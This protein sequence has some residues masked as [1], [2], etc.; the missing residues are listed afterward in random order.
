ME[1]SPRL[2]FKFLQP[3]RSHSWHNDRL[4]MQR[5]HVIQCLSIHTSRFESYI[6]E[7]HGTFQPTISN[8]LIAIMCLCPDEQIR[9]N[10][11]FLPSTLCDAMQIREPDSLLHRSCDQLRER[12]VIRVIAT[13][14]QQIIVIEYPKN[15]CPMMDI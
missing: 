9:R 13:K 4:G 1:K 7:L 14:L 6:P 8:I 2:P 11:Q 12:M 3:S 10:A 5:M 15:Q